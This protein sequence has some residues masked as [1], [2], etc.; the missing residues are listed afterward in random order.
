M[1][2]ESIEGLATLLREA[3]ETNG[4]PI[5]LIADEPYREL[6]YGD[7]DVPYLPHFYKEIGRAH[8]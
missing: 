5:Y 7:V 6:V 2:K 1:T 3:S 8:V 4:Q